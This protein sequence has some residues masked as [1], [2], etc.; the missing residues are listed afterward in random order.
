M[1]P[2]V[3]LC[4]FEDRKTEPLGYSFHDMA[5]YLAER[6]YRLLVSEWFPLRSYGTTGRWRRFAAYPCEMTDR[7]AWGNIIAAAEPRV[8][9]TLQSLCRAFERR[10]RPL[11]PFLRG[12]LG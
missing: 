12:L 6:G 1:T 7:C 10:S 5:R 2:G 3:V 9:E 4:E 11:R 8:F